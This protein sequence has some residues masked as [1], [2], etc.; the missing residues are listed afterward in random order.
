MWFADHAGSSPLSRL[1]LG[2]AALPGAKQGNATVRRNM[3]KSYGVRKGQ[4]KGR[5]RLPGLPATF[6][7]CST[8]RG[9]RESDRHGT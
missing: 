4:E 5:T 9:T 3:G 6:R 1:C 8:V 2:H 7:P